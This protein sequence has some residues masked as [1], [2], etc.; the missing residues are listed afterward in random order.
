MVGQGRG[1][2][3]GNVVRA[4]RRS[5][6][7]VSRVLGKGNCAPRLFKFRATGASLRVKGES[8]FLVRH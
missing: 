8:R 3:E 4:G 6:R 1:V 2:G 5:R 7:S